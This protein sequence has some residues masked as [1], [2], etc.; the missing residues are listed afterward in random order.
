[1]SLMFKI[2]ATAGKLAYLILYPLAKIWLGRTKRAYALISC[3]GEV[4]VIKNWFGRQTWHLPGG[5][6]RKG[7]SP[8]KAASRELQE[9][10][11]ITISEHSLKFVSRGVWQDRKLNFDYEILT[12][13][14]SA[15][16]RLRISRP[17]ILEAV[18]LEPAQLNPTNTPQEI[19]AALR[20]ISFP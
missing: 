17:E 7:E 16:Q 9:E 14:L 20:K 8:L 2:Y 3:G 15:K 10:L 1:M 11:G 5:G 18:W 4:L 6:I 19:L 13:R 12:T